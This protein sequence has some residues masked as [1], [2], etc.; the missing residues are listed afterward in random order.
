MADETSD[1][2]GPLLGERDW[3]AIYRSSPLLVSRL[4]MTSI[5]LDLGWLLVTKQKVDIVFLK[6]LHLLVCVYLCCLMGLI[7][8]DFPHTKMSFTR[9]LYKCNKSTKVKCHNFSVT[10]A[11][12]SCPSMSSTRK[13]CL[14][15]IITDFKKNGYNNALLTHYVKNQ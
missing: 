11:A 7:S 3:A 14:K 15:K 13:S 10:F 8:L 6:K 5:F 1:K 2:L 9:Y 4:H 12:Q